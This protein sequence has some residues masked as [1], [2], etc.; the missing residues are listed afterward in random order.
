MG[1]EPKDTPVLVVTNLAGKVLTLADLSIREL[2]PLKGELVE[3]M[4]AG[5]IKIE[6]A[7]AAGR[8]VDKWEDAWIL[9]L[10]QYETVEDLI[11][12]RKKRYGL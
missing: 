3:R 5:A 10:R 2:E 9:L 8:Q 12:E 11:R 7:R 1:F 4:D 6:Q